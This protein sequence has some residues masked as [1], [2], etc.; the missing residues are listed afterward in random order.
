[1]NVRL[2]RISVGALVVAMVSTLVAVG[3]DEATFNLA[4]DVKT[5]GGLIGEMAWNAEAPYPYG[6]WYGPGWWGGGDAADAPGNRAPVDALDEIAMR[7]DFAYELAE[8]QGKIHGPAEEQRLKAL[9][10]ALAVK[11]AKQLPADPRDWNPPAADPATADRYRRRIGFGFT[12]LSAGR[13][14]G[15]T[16]GKAYTAVK[17]VLDG[18]A[19]TIASSGLTAED[20]ARISRERSQNWVSTTTVVETYRIALSAPRTLLAEGETVPITLSLVPV[21]ATASADKVGDLGLFAEVALDV[22]GPGSLSQYR[23]G[24]NSSVTLTAKTSWFFSNVGYTINVEGSSQVMQFAPVPEGESG[25][26]TNEQIAAGQQYVRSVQILTGSI[27]FKVA[28]PTVLSLAAYPAEVTT[29]PTDSDNPCREIALAATLATKSG[30]GV[31]GV[32]VTFGLPGGGETTAVTN[33]DGIASHIV[34]LCQSELQGQVFA[35]LAYSASAPQTT[36]E[37]GNVYFPSASSVSVRVE[38]PGQKTVRGIVVDGKRDNR[39]VSGATVE[40]KAGEKTWAV[41]T[42]ADG[43]FIVEFDLQEDTPAARQATISVTADGYKPGTGSGMVGG[44]DVRVALEPESAI[45]SIIVRDAE[46]GERIDGAIVRVSEPFPAIVEASNG[47]ASLE[48]FYVGDT[49][50]IS[51][52]GPNHKTYQKT[53]TITRAEAT[54]TFDLPLGEGDESDGDLDATGDEDGDLQLRHSLRI[55]ASPANPDP[56]QNV[57][58]TAQIM[59]PDPGVPIRLGVVGT[60]GYTDSVTS[61]TNAM[62][63]AYLSIPGGAMGVIDRVTILIIGENVQKRLNYSF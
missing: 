10:D 60:D 35:T 47:Q 53:G 3:A 13:D 38:T 4:S 30:K 20:V 55:W 40:V 34:T 48:G 39:P 2:L 62:G 21:S 31:A 42:G 43:R 5:A 1:M 50:T 22:D 7:H 19:P 11:E 56:R 27:D 12:Y 17:D 45:V 41:I 61:M 59:P 29:W 15:A 23:V 46:S 18:K 26:F 51:A 58:V 37:D 16:T 24:I 9:A 63:Q 57:L 28:I 44:A 33:G 6:N 52:G 8:E 14:L 49:A 25:G 54:I 36:T 32:P